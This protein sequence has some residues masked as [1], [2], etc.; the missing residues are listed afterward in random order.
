MKNSNLIFKVVL[1]FLF[2]GGANQNVKAQG[3]CTCNDFIYMND[4]NDDING[5][6]HKFKVNANGTMTE[7][8]NGTS[9]TM[10]WF[11]SGAGLPSPHG[12]GQDLNGNLYIGETNSGPIRKL[13]C[14]GAIVP[15]TSYSITDGGFNINSKDG[16]IYM[17]SKNSDQIRAYDICTGAL[18]G[19]IQLG[20]F[21]GD[22]WGFHIATD[23]RFYSTNSSFGGGSGLDNLYSFKPTLADFASHTVFNPLITNSTYPIPSTNKVATWGITS[24]PSGNFYV[25]V[26]DD[27]VYDTWVLKYNSTGTLI[28]Q[29]KRPWSFSNNNIEKARGLI[30]LNGV[31]YIAGGPNA[32]CV[33]MMDAAT[34]TYTGTAVPHMAGQNP[35]GIALARECCS[36]SATA[37]RDTTLCNPTVNTKLFLQNLIGGNCDGPICGGTWTPDASNSGVSFNACDNSITVN[38]ANGCGKF[39]LAG[40]GGNAQ[41]GVFSLAININLNS[42]K[43]PIIKGNQTVCLGSPT[44]DLSVATAAT[45]TGTL[46][47]QWQK[48]NTSCTAGFTD[49]VGEVNTTLSPGAVSATTYY[50]LVASSTTT[51][52]N[53][54]PCRDTSNCIIVTVPTAI[55]LSCTKTDVT[56]NSLNDGTASVSASGGTAPYT[57]LW[58]NASTTA[59]ISGLVAAT[60]TVTVTDA[61]GCKNTCSSVVTEPGCNVSASAVGVDPKCNL[62]TN[63]TVTLTVTGAVGTPTYLWSNGA[64]TKDLSGV[65]AGTYTVSITDGACKATAMITLNEPTALV[66]VCTKTDATTVGGSDGTATVSPSGATAPYT[67]LWSNGATTATTTGLTA[68]TYAVTVTDANGCTSSCSSIPSNPLPPACNLLDAGLKTYIDQKGT[69]STADDEYVISANPTGSGLATTYNVSGNI[70]KTG[71][72][73][74]SLVEIGRVPIS[75]VTI[76]II[77]TDAGTSSCSVADGAYNLS[78]KTCILLANPTVVCNDNGT[79]TV[80]A[81]DTYSITINPTGNSLSGNYNVSGDLTASNLAYS[82]AQ[83]IATGLA[84]SAGGKTISIIDAIKV[85]CKLLNINIAPPATCSSAIPCPTKLCTPVKVTKL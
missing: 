48:S 32:D 69:V 84:I 81:D 3:A 40:G 28:G 64:T 83:Q 49:I 53:G 72:A 80:P 50:H 10:P 82:T 20:S 8:P 41:C 63:G 78:G 62:G 16:I 85:D 65:G 23:G 52:L 79:P 54:K 33:A 70:T 21:V 45:G 29:Y 46:S 59:S 18:L 30:Y 12:L 43:A 51:C 5:F 4:T 57:Y 55:V 66:L 1:F 37:S 42:I 44:S 47:Y 71:V 22:D 76:N 9:G 38:S 13:N 77:I 74:G 67:Y 25:I 61:N 35:K 75:T 31:L 56:T 36:N 2:F 58:S 27:T 19:Y 24:D 34:M 39:T 14:E 7:M 60:Y 26:E 15:A 17:N 73:Y 6:V 68:N 11:P